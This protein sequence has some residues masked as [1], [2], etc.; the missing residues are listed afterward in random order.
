[1][2]AFAVLMAIAIIPINICITEATV[3]FTHYFDGLLVF[4]AACLTG[5]VI[6]TFKPP[7]P[8]DGT[9]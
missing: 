5:T 7:T 6:E 1:M 2:A 8:T 3:P 4:A 9:S